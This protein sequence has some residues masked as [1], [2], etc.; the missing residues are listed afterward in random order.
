V[1]VSAG[2]YSAPTRPG[3]SAQMRETS[4][5]QYRFPDGEAWRPG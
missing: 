5:A 4:L 1:E 2:R 3:F